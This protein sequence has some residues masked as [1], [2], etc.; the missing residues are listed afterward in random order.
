MVKRPEPRN[1]RVLEFTSTGAAP[2]AGPPPLAGI[3]IPTRES[4]PLTSALYLSLRVPD[5]CLVVG[6]FAISHWVIVSRCGTSAAELVAEVDARTPRPSMVVSMHDQW[7]QER[8]R[9]VS[10]GAH[11][12]VAVHTHDAPLS[13]CVRAILL[14]AGDG[15]LWATPEASEIVATMARWDGGHNA[16]V[17]PVMALGQ[18]LLCQDEQVRNRKDHVWRGSR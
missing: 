12:G 5:T 9:M 11:R 18:L 7:A 8:A 13:P 4:A 10:V 14:V 2:P 17:R 15:R 1:P 16:D 6:R 3:R